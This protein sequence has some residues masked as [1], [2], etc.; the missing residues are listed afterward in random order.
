M[1]FYFIKIF[2]KKF[3]KE[4]DISYIINFSKEVI[5][6]V[7]IRGYVITLII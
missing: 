7:E 3:K 4:L 6:F 1:H 5:I 2:I